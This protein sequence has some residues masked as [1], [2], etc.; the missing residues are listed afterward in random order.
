MS[1]HYFPEDYC[2]ICDEC[3]IAEKV[4]SGHHVCKPSWVVWVKEYGDRP[5]DGA[6]VWAQD[7]E[8]AATKYADEHSTFETPEE[9]TVCVVSKEIAEDAMAE[10]DETPNTDP[11]DFMPPENLKTYL[12]SSEYVRLWYATE[13]MPTETEIQND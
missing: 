5:Q 3:I 8:E 4:L 13:V 6:T 11:Q 7:A 9:I 12:L 1:N 10:S 2:P